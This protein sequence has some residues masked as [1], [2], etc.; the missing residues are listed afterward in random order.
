VVEQT[1]VA[2]VKVAPDT[3]VLVLVSTG[4][5]PQTTVPVPD[6]IG[7]Q[8]TAAQTAL[9]DTGL[10]GREIRTYSTKPKGEVVS[11]EPVSGTKVAEGTVV[12]LLVSAGP[13]PSTPPENPPTYPKPPGNTPKPPGDTPEPPAETPATPK[14]P[15]IETVKVP[16]VLGLAEE[17]AIAALLKAGLDAIVV[18][19]ASDDASTGEVIAQLPEAGE[20][21][22]KGYSV[23]LTIATDPTADAPSDQPGGTEDQPKE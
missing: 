2:G 17:E 5:P 10:K 4:P 22:T 3:E 7:K 9:E 16:S 6:V 14:P 1:P 19:Y 23:L 20:Y 11:Q 13:Q 21:V 12:G 8:A 15:M 18:P